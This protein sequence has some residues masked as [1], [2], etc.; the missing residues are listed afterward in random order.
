MSK[1]LGDI[2]F[3]FSVEDGIYRVVYNKSLAE[4]P[5]FNRFV[6]VIYWMMKENPELVE[7]IL[8]VALKASEELIT[9]F[10]NILNEK[11]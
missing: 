9:P 5:G 4:G 1:I 8:E 6:G 10:N 11:K 2:I 7:Q 3:S